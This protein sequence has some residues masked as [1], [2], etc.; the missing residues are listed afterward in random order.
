MVDKQ[1]YFRMKSSLL[2]ILGN[3]FSSSSESTVL[4]SYKY[5][6]TP[7]IIN[8]IAIEAPKYGQGLYT[9]EQIKYILHECFTAYSAAKSLANK[10]YALNNQR[11]PTSPIKT[12]IHSGW[13]GCGA[14]GGNRIIM[15]ILQILAVKMAGIDKLIL[16]TVTSNFRQEIDAA[17]TCLKNI[18][19][20]NQSSLSMDD[21]ID[22]IVTENFQWGSSNGT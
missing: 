13:F 3:N 22:R 10:T 4:K 2:S 14:Y 8:I 7:Q 17:E 21:V 15:I 16:H 20:N 11:N 6:K 1:S 19:N 18:F 5:L 12:Y 9:P